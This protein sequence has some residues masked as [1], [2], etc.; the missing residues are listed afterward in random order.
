MAEE[1]EGEEG[2]AAEDGGSGSKVPE[3]RRVCSRSS[4]W[5]ATFFDWL[6]SF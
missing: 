1:A 2:A 5:M 4:G 6:H 3:M